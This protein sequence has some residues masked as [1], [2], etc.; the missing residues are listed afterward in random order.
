MQWWEITSITRAELGHSV[1][2]YKV[3]RDIRNF[4]E[5]RHRSGE[6]DRRGGGEARVAADCGDCEDR[7]DIQGNGWTW[8]GR[9][10]GLG[11]DLALSP[12]RP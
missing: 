4:S 8:A 10:R 2:I 12:R 6:E 5:G 7:E 11:P 3:T 9:G 1:D